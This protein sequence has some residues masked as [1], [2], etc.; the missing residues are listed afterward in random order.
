METMWRLTQDWYGDRL[1]PDFR[2]RPVEEMQ[3]KLMRVG[4]R[5]DFWQLR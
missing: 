3:A 2:P 1:D 5:S 4:L